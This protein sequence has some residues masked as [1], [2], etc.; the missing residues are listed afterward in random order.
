M[1]FIHRVVGIE[2]FMGLSSYTNPFSKAAGL[3][4]SPLLLCFLIFLGAS[5]P[6]PSPLADSLMTILV[7]VLYILW[8]PFIFVAIILREIGERVYGPPDRKKY[9]KRDIL[10]IP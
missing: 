1:E 9:Q 4:M 6:S 7:P 3:L 5:W 10:T 8:S 2:R